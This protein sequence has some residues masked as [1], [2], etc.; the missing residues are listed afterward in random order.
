ELVVYV[1]D[2]D[3]KKVHHSR[4]LDWRKGQVPFHAGIA[5]PQAFWSPKGDRLLLSWDGKAGLYEF[6]TGKVLDLPGDVMTFG[7]RP[8][9]PDGEVFLLCRMEGNGKPEGLFAADWSGTAKEIKGMG[10]VPQ[11]AAFPRPI[12]LVP[13]F[14]ASSWDGQAATAAW[15]GHRLRVDTAR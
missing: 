2:R 15:S 10:E 1:Y 12:A 7:D 4:K 14:Y 6:A 13:W 11:D 9:R 3:G 8:V 5:V